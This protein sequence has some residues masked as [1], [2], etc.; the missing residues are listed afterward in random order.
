[1]K[2]VV[3]VAFCAAM[4]L[5]NIAA[6]NSPSLT[7]KGSTFGFFQPKYRL[8]LEWKQRENLIFELT[9][10]YNHYNHLAADAF[11]GSITKEYAL[12]RIYNTNWNGNSTYYDSGWQYLGEGRPIEN[13][14][15]PKV[16]NLSTFRINI[17]FRKSNYLV[18]KRLKY[19]FQP[20]VAL[21][22]HKTYF[23]GT[24]DKQI[25]QKDYGVW[26][27]GESNNGTHQAMQT[28]YYTQSQESYL[29]Q[30]WLAGPAFQF[31]LSWNIV[32]GLSVEPRFNIAIN[33]GEK[34]L[35]ESNGIYE[36]GFMY[37]Q[38]DFL[39]CYAINLRNKSKRGEK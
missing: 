30:Y 13:P 29:K 6:Q 20:S 33:F 32:K 24:P 34:Y 21:A 19:F 8:A 7:I 15:E 27:I 1:M 18:S 39:V 23:V 10:S 9:G 38:L 5:N 2:K 14:A 22:V 37:G 4:L 11:V 26:Q 12:R 35:P 36:L 16:T 28:V 31:G 17:G 25:L 3:I